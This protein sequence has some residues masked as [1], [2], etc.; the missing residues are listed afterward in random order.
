LHCYYV[1]VALL[2]LLL[3]LLL[4]VNFIG[5]ICGFHFHYCYYDCYYM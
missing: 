3:L 2:L 5:S 4:Y 1:W